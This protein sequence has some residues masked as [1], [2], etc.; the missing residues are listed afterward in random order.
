[1]LPYA[2]HTERVHPYQKWERV[3]QWKFIT[4]VDFRRK[5]ELSH[6]YWLVGDELNKKC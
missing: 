5:T 2:Q 6:A 4:N 3:T 1:M